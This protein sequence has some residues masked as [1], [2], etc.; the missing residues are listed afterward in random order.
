MEAHWLTLGLILYSPDLFL[1]HKVV[2][3]RR[4]MDERKM[5]LLWVPLGPKQD[6]S[7]E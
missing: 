2:V 7:I 1:S 4:K 5:P 6:I 3:V